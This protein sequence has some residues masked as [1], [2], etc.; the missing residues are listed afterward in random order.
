MKQVDETRRL[1]IALNRADVQFVIV[2]GVAMIIRGSAYLT[3]DLD[4]VYSRT[5]ENIANLVKALLPF[6]PQLR[7]SGMSVKFL[8]DERTLKNGMNFTLTTSLG[9]ID[10]LGE[11]AGLGKY[12]AVRKFADSV[13]FGNERFEVLSLDGLIKTKKASGR[14]KDLQA[15]PELRALKELHEATDITDRDGK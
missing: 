7:T 11:I 10:L 3:E 2:G 6:A 4:I 12:E 15:L 1:L 14:T 8:F 5:K 13:A 9:S